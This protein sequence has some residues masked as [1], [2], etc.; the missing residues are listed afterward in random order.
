MAASAAIF[1]DKIMFIVYSKENCPYCVQSKALLK[2]KGLEYLELM[3]DLGQA[4]KADIEYVFLKDLEKLLPGV[5]S[6]PQIFERLGGAAPATQHIG[7]F[8]ELREY[9]SKS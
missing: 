7:G 9:L 6:V 4:K 8:K 3:L 1:I 5:S 2:S